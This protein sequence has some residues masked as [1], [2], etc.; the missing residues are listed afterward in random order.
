LNL[1]GKRV[2]V[3][4]DICTNGRSLDVARAYIEAAGG[5]A[6]LFCWL[7]TVNSSFHHMSPTPT[8]EAYTSNTI[9]LEPTSVLFHYGSQISNGSAA[10]EIA[11]ALPAFKKWRWP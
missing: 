2:L 6:T 4:D 5:T 10:Q 1:K 7:K 3:I 11:A 8:L 9:S